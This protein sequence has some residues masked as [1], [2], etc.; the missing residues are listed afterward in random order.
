MKNLSP[1]AQQQRGLTMFSFLFF[2]IV[3]IAI[4]MLAMKLVPAYIEFFSVKKILATMG[5]DPDLKSKSNADI[6][7]DFSKRASVGY[8]TVVKPEDIDVER[9]AGVPVISVEY[10]YRTKLVG[11]VSLVVDFSASS[12]PNAAPVEVE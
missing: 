6:R 8:V 4:A 5:Q 2:A 12:D 11:N 7:N 1:L 9:Q 10:E 3:F